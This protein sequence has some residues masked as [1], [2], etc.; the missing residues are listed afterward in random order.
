MDIF[1][2][3]RGWVKQWLQMTGALFILD[4][5][6]LTGEPYDYFLLSIIVTRN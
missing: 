6:R 5:S 4:E 1:F 3:L 2:L